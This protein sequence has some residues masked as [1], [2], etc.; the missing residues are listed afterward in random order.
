M[1]Q[2]IRGRVVLAV[3]AE[4]VVELDVAV[5]LG[6]AQMVDAEVRHDSI[7]P[8]VE[9]RVALEL[10]DVSMDLDEALLHDVERVLLIAEESESDRVDFALIAL[11]QDFEGPFVT[12][13]YGGDEGEV[14]GVWGDHVFVAALRRLLGTAIQRLDGWKSS[15]GRRVEVCTPHLRRL[16]PVPNKPQFARGSIRELDSEGYTQWSPS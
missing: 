11:H 6:L 2:Q 9:A 15:S 12:A 7:Q 5:A 3:V 1:R 8:G 14:L 4:P 16:R 10:A 13:L